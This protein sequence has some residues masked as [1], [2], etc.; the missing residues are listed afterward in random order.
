[1][2][3]VLFSFIALV[4][5]LTGCSN[6][7]EAQS[8]ELTSVNVATMRDI[9]YVPFIY[10]VEE[11]M[12][13]EA[14]LDVDITFFDSAPDR[15]AAWD[16]GEFDME[17]ADLTA[18]ALLG[19]NGDDIQ[20]TGAPRGA[21]KL[22]ASPEV[23]ESFNGDIASLDGMSV[24]LSE[25]TV[26]EFYVDYLANDYDIEF[27]KTPIPSIP[28][29]YSALLSGEIDLAIL[30]DP[31]PTMAVEE[32]ADLIWQ[33]TEDGVTD[34][35]GLNWQG[36]VSSETIDT[37]LEV[38]NEAVDKVNEAGADSYKE[39]AISYELVDEQYFDAITDGLEF[40]HSEAPSKDTWDEVETWALD[41][42]M[43]ENKV[44]YDE[45]VY[46]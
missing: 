38:S 22:V 1:M 14:G 34:L 25:N 9:S 23:S 31:F 13:E 6:N 7:E 27:D 18:G 40:T 17:T 21:Y 32:G 8:G 20:I 12:Y 19:S 16:S 15:N 2:K 30:P 45:I 33:S 41:K 29:R 39:Y 35:A 37:F 11:G 26:I 43:I 24:G 4:L 42:G 28:D 44:D 3:I 36:N 5:V 46:Q 10:A